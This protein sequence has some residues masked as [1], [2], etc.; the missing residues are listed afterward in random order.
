MRK[1][2]CTELTKEELIKG[3]ISYI[4]SDN[5]VYNSSHEPVKLFVNRQGYLMFNCYALDDKGERIKYY[6]PT[7]K[8]KSMWN[9]KTRPIILSR[10]IWAWRYGSVP[11]G[12]VV[13]HINNQHYVLEDYDIDNLQLLTPG[14]NIQ[15]ERPEKYRLIKCSLK[16]PR[17]YYEERLAHFYEEYDLAK[18]AH[19]AKRVHLARCNISMTRGRLNYY[20]RNKRTEKVVN[21]QH[22][23]QED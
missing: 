18:K 20:D 13:D 2:Y 11:A 1:D 3:G 4:D 12:Y 14:Q 10:A 19:D 17:S 16:R 21:E 5:V 8:Y 23:L 22:V 15:K 6:C 7:R 9:W